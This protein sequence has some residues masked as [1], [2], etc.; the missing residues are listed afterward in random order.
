MNELQKAL[1]N[2]NKQLTEDIIDDI[3]YRIAFHEKLLSQ[4]LAF[5]EECVSKGLM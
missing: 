3:E 1:D 4:A 2:F 5:R